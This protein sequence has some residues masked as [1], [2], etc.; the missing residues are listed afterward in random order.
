[1]IR[2]TLSILV[3]PLDY[4]R[5]RHDAK[6]VLDWW[7]PLVAAAVITSLLLLT[8]RSQLL[9]DRGLIA[10]FNGLLQ[11]LTGFYIAA[12][13]AV[14]TFQKSG[15][16][17]LMAGNPPRLLITVRG[18]DREIRLTRRRFL[19]LM[20]GYLA[21]LSLFMYLG[22]LFAN[23]LAPDLVARLPLA[24]HK[25]I[26]LLGTFLYTLVGSNLVVTT[27]VGLY[28]MSDRI[29][30]PDSSLGSSVEQDRPVD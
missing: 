12:L 6:V 26:A 14:A 15:I 16:D 8:E 10:G 2:H 1:M 28:Y 18:E 13:A 24:L 29:H 22:G 11:V 4:L 27:L 9:G 5:I 19:C 30:R 3:R 17:E 21:F 20:F 25:P 7:V 23:L